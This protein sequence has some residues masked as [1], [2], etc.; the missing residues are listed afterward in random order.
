MLCEVFPPVEVFKTNVME[1]LDANQLKEALEHHFPGMTANFALD[2][3]DRVLRVQGEGI[4]SQKIMEWL[5]SRGF[6]ADILE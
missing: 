3:C 5:R 4:D 2:D 1:A 6:K